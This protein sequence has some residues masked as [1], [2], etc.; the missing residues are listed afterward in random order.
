MVHVLRTGVSSDTRPLAFE[1]VHGCAALSPRAGWGP[2]SEMRRGDGDSVLMG[3]HDPV[4][5]ALCTAPFSLPHSPEGKLRRWHILEFGTEPPRRGAVRP[6]GQRPENLARACGR[7]EPTGHKPLLPPAPACAREWLARGPTAWG[8]WGWRV[9]STSRRGLSLG[10]WGLWQEDPGCTEQPQLTVH[11]RP[12]SEHQNELE[13]STEQRRMSL[14]QARGPLQTS[15]KARDPLP[16]PDVPS[17]HPLQF[18]PLP[19][20]R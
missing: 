7:A 19:Q 4:P 5:A 6:R 10:P 17:V 18:H 11:T 15:R 13:G 14:S 2:L 16:V 20:R 1:V 8:W 3:V 9:S 12:Q